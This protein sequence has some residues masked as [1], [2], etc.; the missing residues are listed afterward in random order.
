MQQMLER[1]QLEVLDMRRRL[2]GLE[3]RL[4]E[5]EGRTR[6]ED[7]QEGINREAGGDNDLVQT[8]F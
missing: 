7:G 1:H 6:D 3:I 2:L 4:W 5:K 8:R